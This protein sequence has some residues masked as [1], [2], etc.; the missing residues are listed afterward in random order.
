MKI[1][2]KFDMKMEKAKKKAKPCPFHIDTKKMTMSPSIFEM[3]KKDVPVIGIKAPFPIS[4]SLPK[5]RKPSIPSV[6]IK[7]SLHSWLEQS[8]QLI[9]PSTILQE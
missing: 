6:K 8:N 5:V 9:A 1:K 2:G 4:L 3:T 7:P